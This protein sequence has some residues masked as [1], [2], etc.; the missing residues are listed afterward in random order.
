MRSVVTE[1][2]QEQLQLTLETAARDLLAYFQ[3]RV[4]D[5][6]DAADLLSETMLQAWRRGDA[7]PAQDERRRMWLF[8]IASNVLANHR[9][10]AGRRD[11]LVDKVRSVLRAVP[12]EVDVGEAAALRDA[13]RRLPDH[14]RELIM[15]VHWDGFSLSNAADILAINA[16]T[17]RSR[18]CSA[19]AA[20]QEALTTTAGCSSES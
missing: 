15:L 7:A 2:A 18:Y 10:A 4:Q 8:T 5:R 12:D 1:P 13:V 9:R 19:R 16:S 14:Q 11:A 17:A 3:R 20:L 6:E